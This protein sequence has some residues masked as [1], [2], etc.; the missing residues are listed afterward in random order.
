MDAVDLDRANEI[1]LGEIRTNTDA[2]R[3]LIYEVVLGY[4]IK[5][6]ETVVSGFF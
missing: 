1:G 4:E 6:R 5:W 2:G 3:V